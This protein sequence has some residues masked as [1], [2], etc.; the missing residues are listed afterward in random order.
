MRLEL[1]DKNLFFLVSGFNFFAALVIRDTKKIKLES[2]ASRQCSAEASVAP[3][4]CRGATCVG[5]PKGRS[6]AQSSAYSPVAT[7]A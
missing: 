3:A 1:Q 6:R 7:A 2:D 5:L 4:R